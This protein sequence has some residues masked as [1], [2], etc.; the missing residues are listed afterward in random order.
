VSE[1][2]AAL[3]R[4]QKKHA[5][6]FRGMHLVDFV[7]LRC[8]WAPFGCPWASFGFPLALFG[9]PLVHIGNFIENWTSVT[10]KC[11]KFMKQ[12]TKTSFLEF[13]SG[14]SG[15]RGAHGIP[16]VVSASA[17][18]TSLPHGQDDGS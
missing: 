14:A 7:S 1:L 13:A 4:P 5:L 8:P 17:A 11:V 15:A 12:S 16:E 6:E 10:E 9:G 18:Q 2:P 3:R